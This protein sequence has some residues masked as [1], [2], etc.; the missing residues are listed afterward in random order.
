[1]KRAK[2]PFLCLVAV[3]LA[4]S[5]P[6]IPTITP[7]AESTATRSPE[8]TATRLVAAQSQAYVTATR[9]LN[10]RVRPGERERVIG[11]LYFGDLVTLTGECSKDPKGWAQIE[12][13]DGTAW[14]RAKFLSQNKCSEE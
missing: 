11:A 4:C 5:G 13:Q 7:T 2:L 14:V 1:M 12:W 3:V 9:S 8:A 10:V 6:T